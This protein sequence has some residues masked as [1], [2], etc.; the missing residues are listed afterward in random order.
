[1]LV[2]YLPLGVAP[3][4]DA[5]AARAEL[6][7]LPGPGSDTPGGGAVPAVRPAVP[8]VPS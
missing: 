8:P 5:G 2:H 1:M 6:D 7:V 4:E 3:L